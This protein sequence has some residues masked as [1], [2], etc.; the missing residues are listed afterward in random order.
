MNSTLQAQNET[1][2]V[3]PEM[4]P[5]E[6]LAAYRRDGFTIFRGIHPAERLRAW[7]DAFPGLSE[8]A[9]FLGGDPFDLTNLLELAPE[10]FLPAVADPR[11]LDFAEAVMGPRVQLDSIHFRMDGSQP[12]ERRLMPVE[13]HRDMNAVFPPADGAYLHPL[14]VNVITYP[15]GL[16][17]D[18]GPLRVVPGS[19]VRRLEMSREERLRPHSEEV[20]LR[21]NPG[22]VVF[23]HNGLWHS[24]SVNVTT[25]PR[26][27][28][29]VY[30]HVNWLPTR[31]NHHGPNL[32]QLRAKAR[33]QKDRRLLRLLGEDER[34]LEHE[35][36]TG[37]EPEERTWARWIAQD[38]E[39]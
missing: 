35:H 27:F 13:W 12:P 36:G 22:D 2:V 37:M 33:A 26:W 1:V 15:Q 30:F 38:R 6:R 8:R 5:E 10:L 32:S 28:V 4:T 24:G 21:P 17:D 7:C 20:L 25:Q 18:F 31:D 34:R 14:A 16:N 39:A 19:H 23:T 11:L 3:P 29:S 9:S